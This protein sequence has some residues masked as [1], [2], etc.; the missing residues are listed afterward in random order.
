MRTRTFQNRYFAARISTGVEARIEVMGELDLASVPTF[1]AAA[2]DLDVS[3]RRRVVL[4]LGRL[5]FIDAAGLHAVLKLHEK[6]LS[7][8]TPLTILP[9]PRHVQR[10]FELAGADEVLRTGAPGGRR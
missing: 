8:S 1:D 10:V 2:R 9:G 3:C 7:V 5:A 4:D 6:C